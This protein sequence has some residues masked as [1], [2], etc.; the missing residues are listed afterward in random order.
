MKD[1][2]YG[3]GYEMYPEDGKSCLPE[4]LAGRRYLL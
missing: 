3:K 1:E 2:G 4:K